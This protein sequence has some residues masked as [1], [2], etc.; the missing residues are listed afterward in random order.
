MSEQTIERA[1]EPFFSTKG[2]GPGLGLAVVYETVTQH[3]GR[4][5]VVSKSGIGTTVTVDIPSAEITSAMPDSPTAARN[6]IVPRTGTALIVDDEPLMLRTGERVL[7]RLGYRVHLAS[8]GKQALEIYA[9]YGHGISFVL[10]DLIMPGMDGAE[11][12]ET[13]RGIDPAVKVIISSGFGSDASHAEMIRLGAVGHV[14]KP[15]TVQ[16]LQQVLRETL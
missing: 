12:L 9:K 11:V 14:D 13:L 1:F 5:G 2:K 6:T 7:G 4:I 10:L 16:Q 8:S 15:Y 3:G